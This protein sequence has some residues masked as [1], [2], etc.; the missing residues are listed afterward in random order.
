M[1]NLSIGMKTEPSEGQWKRLDWFKG[2][3]RSTDSD[4]MLKE[5]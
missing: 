1:E 2:R 3:K 4:E 5:S